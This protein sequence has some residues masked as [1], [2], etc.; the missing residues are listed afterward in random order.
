MIVQATM[1]S[2]VNLSLSG[3][4]C[5]RRTEVAGPTRA[6]EKA[7]GA[8]PGRERGQDRQGERTCR[9]TRWEGNQGLS[10]SA[11]GQD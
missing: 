6:L 2:T 9:K 11:G 8:G 4:S 1:A 3:K 7:W 10:G 5:C